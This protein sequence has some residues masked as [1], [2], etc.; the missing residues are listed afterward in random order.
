MRNRYSVTRNKGRDVNGVRAVFTCHCLLAGVDLFSGSDTD[1]ISWTHLDADLLA[2]DDYGRAL[3]YDITVSFYGIDLD[4]DGY[5]LEDM[6]KELRRRVQYVAVHL[7]VFED[8]MSYERY[9]E[10]EDCLIEQSV[11][12]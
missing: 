7:V 5:L 11:I 1:P 10:E 12:G 9:M 2:V 3:P 8:L 6:P 4:R